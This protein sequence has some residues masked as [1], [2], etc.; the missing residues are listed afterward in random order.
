MGHSSRQTR[1][2]CG[3]HRPLFTGLAAEVY[4][5]LLGFY[6]VEDVSF[7]GVR[8][9]KG[10]PKVKLPSRWRCLEG[11]FVTVCDG[12]FGER[13]IRFMA[14]KPGAILRILRQRLEQRKI[15]VCS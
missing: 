7:A 3:K 8:G 15:L 13:D 6:G 5:I 12:E 10:E 9:Y 4:D 1:R 14:T 11:V 2:V